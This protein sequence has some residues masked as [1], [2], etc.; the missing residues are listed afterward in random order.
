MYPA[1]QI[2]VGDDGSEE[3]VREICESYHDA[4]IVYVARQPTLRM[5][6]NWNFVVRWAERGLV[7]LLEDDNY[8]LPGHLENA[9]KLFERFPDAGIYHAGHQEAWDRNDNLE[10]YRTYFPP[11]HT[12]L[13]SAGGGYVPAQEIVLDALICGSINSSTTVVQRALL[14][15]VP[16]FEHRYLMGMDTLMWTRLAMASPCIYGAGLDTIYTYHGKNVSTGE[17]Q[18]R[19]AGYQARA[20]R[21]LIAIE[22]LQKGII[23]PEGIKHWLEQLPAG[24]AA[25]VLT[26]LGHRDTEPSL[27][28]VAREIWAL[29]GDVRATTGYLRASSILGWSVLEQADRIDVLLGGFARMKQVVL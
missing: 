27:R 15:R 7:A 13:E 20:S 16:P 21:R 25:G 24:D 9:K 4:R 19:R 1:D 10:I 11:W 29:R 2:V 17:I 14:E 26:I 12:R 23:S 6:D 22:A 28:A 3:Q 5:T 8:W 18:T